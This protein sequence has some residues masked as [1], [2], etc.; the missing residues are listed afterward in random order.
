MKEASCQINT[1]FS[2][3]LIKWNLMLQC[4]MWSSR[5]IN[6][7]MQSLLVREQKMLEDNESTGC[8]ITYKCNKCW[9]WKVCKQHS[10]DETISVKEEV[11]QDETKKSVKVDV[12]SPRTT[13]SLQLMNNSWGKLAHNKE[14]T[15]KV[16]NQ[17]TKELNQLKDDKKMYLR[18]KKNWK[19]MALLIM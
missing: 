17:Q 5:T 7:M 8:K 3:Q 11:E 6:W 12:A 18:Q 14:R 15:L 16:C 19:V 1:S 2:S 4:C 13:A 9:T 10:A